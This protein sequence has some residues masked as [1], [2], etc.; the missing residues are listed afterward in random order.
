MVIQVFYQQETEQERPKGLKKLQ[1]TSTQTE[2][3]SSVCTVV[4]KFAAV[5]A[6]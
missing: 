2:S 6:V 5:I 3:D 1:R 4:L